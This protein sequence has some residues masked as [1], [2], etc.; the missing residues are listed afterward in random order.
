MKTAHQIAA[1]IAANVA[2]HGTQKFMGNKPYT[3]NEFRA[4]IAE[5]AILA[6]R[7]QRTVPGAAESYRNSGFNNTVAAAL[8]DALTDRETDEADAAAEWV[9]ENENDLLWDLY[10]GPLMDEIE[11]RVTR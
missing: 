11:R 9:A 4:E 3:P 6:D 8:Y 7:A 1:E 5:R 2:E 10:I